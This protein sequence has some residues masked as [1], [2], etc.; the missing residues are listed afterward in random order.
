M[1][2][3]SSPTYGIDLLAFLESLHKKVSLEGK[4]VVNQNPF[5]GAPN[6]PWLVVYVNNKYKYLV[7]KVWFVWLKTDWCQVAG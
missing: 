6:P 3:T 1:F 7:W 2:L 5:F 4:V